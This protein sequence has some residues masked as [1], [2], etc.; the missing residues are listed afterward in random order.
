[1][2]TGIQIGE[3]RHSKG[4]SKHNPYEFLRHFLLFLNNAESVDESA[5]HIA[6]ELGDSE[7]RLDLFSWN[8][9]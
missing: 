1:M 5:L 2:E 3:R 6:L 9:T 7:N 4:R 8:Q